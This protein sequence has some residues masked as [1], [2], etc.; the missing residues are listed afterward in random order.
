MATGHAHTK[1]INLSEQFIFSDRLKRI[2]FGLMIVGALFVGVDFLMHMNDAP[3]E[4]HHAAQV[5][6]NNLDAGHH[7]AEKY[8]ETTHHES[9]GIMGRLFSNLLLNSYYLVWMGLAGLFF[10]AVQYLSN[11]G[12]SVGLLRIPLAFSGV[13][14]YAAPLIILVLF[15]GIQNHTLYNHWTNP[16]FMDPNSPLFDKL[17]KGKEVLLN[18]PFFIGISIVFFG[19]WLFFRQMYIKYS[20]NEDKETEVSMKIFDKQVYLSA[21]YIPI[22]AL[23]FCTAAFL[24]MMSLEPHWFS[25]MFAVYNF[26]SMWVSGL[27]AMT[28]VVIILKENGYLSIINENHIH[29][30]GKFVFAFSIF[31][32]YLWLS[33]FLLIWYANL[34]E[35]SIY[36]LNRWQPEYKSLFWANLLINFVAPLLMLMRRDWKRRLNWLKFVCGVVIIGHWLD[37]YL[38]IMPGTMGAERKIGF[39][40]I[41]M[42]VF[43]IG[44]FAFIMFKALARLPLFQKNHPY[45]EEAI[46][47]EVA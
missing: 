38:M 13:L 10:V 23:T 2:C 34:P 14:P 24:W 12:W 15:F 19:I 17:L 45:M 20:V 28:I 33:Q 8:N 43:F 6:L 26:A 27:A 3:A 44:L 16:G 29:D 41:G 11:A 4:M 7:I 32:T 35:E 21:F 46:H 22:Y 9:P 30:L 36:F 47:H 25:T 40:E 37:I 5:E 1:Q 18:V 42:F 39:M 31:W